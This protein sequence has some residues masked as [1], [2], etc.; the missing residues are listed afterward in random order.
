[1]K[2]I[3]TTYPISTLII[4]LIIFLSLFNPPQTQLDNVSNMDKIAH[5]CMYG[6]LE[7]IIWIE[8]LRKRTSPPY[9][10][11]ILIMF[12]IPVIIGAALE[13]AQSVLTDYRSCEMFDLIAD[14]AGTVAGLLAGW[15]YYKLISG[16]KQV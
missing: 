15:L 2:K 13:L 6:G 12:L 11:N 14:M 4:V 10:G 9:I 16:K 8:Y 3:L 7:L 1:M 5:F